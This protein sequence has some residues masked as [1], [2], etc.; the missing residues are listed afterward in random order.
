MAK[1][2]IT[3]ML[4]IDCKILIFLILNEKIANKNKAARASI[5][6]SD[7]IEIDL[8]LAAFKKISVGEMSP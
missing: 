5:F 6:K 8:K 4:F 2:D 3:R 7:I 1:R